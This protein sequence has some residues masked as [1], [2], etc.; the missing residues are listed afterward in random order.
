MDDNKFLRRKRSA[1]DAPET[2]PGEGGR[3]GVVRGRG[4]GLRGELASEGA[5]V[6]IKV[7]TQESRN[8]VDDDG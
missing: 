6:I 8:D 7:T 3:E 4:R 2:M 5:R 1:L